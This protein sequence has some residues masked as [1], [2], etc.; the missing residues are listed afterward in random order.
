MKKVMFLFLLS[1]GT[2]FSVRAQKTP[3][4]TVV[5][6]FNQKFPGMTDVDWSKEK[7]GEWEAEFEQGDVEISANFSANGAWLETE[8]EIS[9]TALPQAA[10]DYL[11]VNFKGKKVKEASKIVTPDGKTT[12]EAEV[13]GRG[14]LMFDAD[15][16]YLEAGKK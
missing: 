16:K 11:A 5:T 8:T 10:L 1:L 2:S 14:D 6:A 15:G 12:Y 3:P 13:K 7:N 9:V 4:Q